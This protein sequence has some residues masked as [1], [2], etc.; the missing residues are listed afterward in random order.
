MRIRSVDISVI[1]RSVLIVL[2]LCASAMLL[3]GCYRFSRKIDPLLGGT[4]EQLTFDYKSH[5]LN[6]HQ[7]FSPDDKWIVYDTRI[8]GGSIGSSGVVEKVNVKTGEMI[9]MYRTPDQSRHGPGAGAAAYNPVS[10][11]IIFARGLLGSN[12]S[13]RTGSGAEAALLLKTP[14]R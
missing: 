7:C 11:R 13:G 14:S 2:A 6:S 3:S 12:F 4:E 5:Y 9:V 10:E 1:Y 8:A